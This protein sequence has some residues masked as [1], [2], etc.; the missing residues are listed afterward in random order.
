MK[1]YRTTGINSDKPLD[2]SNAV[3]K[4][5]KYMGE[6]IRAAYTGE[7]TKLPKSL[8]QCLAVLANDYHL[9]DI[10][11]GLNTGE[12]YRP[13]KLLEGLE[14]VCKD[15]NGLV[16][17]FKGLGMYDGRVLDL[18]FLFHYLQTPDRNIITTL[19]VTR[20][21][22]TEDRVTNPKATRDF[23][24]F[25]QI[26]DLLVTAFKEKSIPNNECKEG[27]RL[28]K[29]FPYVH[30]ANTAFV[31]AKDVTRVPPSCEE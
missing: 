10:P 7:D 23:L 26:Y 19:K 5:E 3:M 12:D 28:V 31:Q 6:M 25:C 4:V 18:C 27:A 29:H 9:N 22:M 13:I 1:V 15:A 24:G 8:K 16:E 20:D 11:D 2:I 17:L 14:E 30:T 21:K